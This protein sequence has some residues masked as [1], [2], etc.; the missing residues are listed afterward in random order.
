MRGR[1]LGTS[2]GSGERRSY[3]GERLLESKPV[4]ELFTEKKQGLRLQIPDLVLS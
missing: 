3:E 4:N 1:R 2:A